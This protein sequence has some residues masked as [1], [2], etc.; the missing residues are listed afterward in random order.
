L[1]CA[2]Q[3][4]NQSAGALS[5]HWRD[6]SASAKSCSSALSRLVSKRPSASP[7]PHIGSCPPLTRV[8]A[9]QEHASRPCWCARSS[10][11]GRG[12]HQARE[13]QALPIQLNMLII[14][15]LW[16]RKPPR[17][18]LRR[19]RQHRDSEVQRLHIRRRSEMPGSVQF[20]GID[21]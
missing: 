16:S 2:C 14:V 8:V 9:G 12:H 13:R 5:I 3:L 4:G 6:R 7:T 17:K 21:A 20:T 11:Y 15:V 19:L 10:I 1:L 18:T